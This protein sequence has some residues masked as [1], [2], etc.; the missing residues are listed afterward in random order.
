MCDSCKGSGWITATHNQTGYIYAFRCHCPVPDRLG[1]SN[2]IPRWHPKNA[3]TMTPD[4]GSKYNVATT[5]KPD[6]KTMSAEPKR[7]DDDDAPF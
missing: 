7:I 4:H 5:K 3:N 1:L 2:T 6:F